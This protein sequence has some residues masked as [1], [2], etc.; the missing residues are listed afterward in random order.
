MPPKKPS[1]ISNL[2][3]ALTVFAKYG[4]VE[5]P[6]YCEHDELYVNVNPSDVSDEDKLELY[7]LGFNEGDGAF[8]SSRYGSA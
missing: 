1:T 7:V 8:Y 2:I 3:D 6:T 4:D 5:Y